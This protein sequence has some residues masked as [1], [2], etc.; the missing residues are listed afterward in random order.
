MQ[1][2]HRSHERRR[3]HRHARMQMLG[4][5]QQLAAFTALPRRLNKRSSREIVLQSLC[6]LPPLRSA[7]RDPQAHSR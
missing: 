1:V 7:S 4:L 5:T 2:T 3:G 6:E